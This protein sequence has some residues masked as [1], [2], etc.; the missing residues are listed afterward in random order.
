MLKPEKVRISPRTLLR[1]VVD[2][3]RIRSQERGLSL[4][5]EFDGPLPDS[6]LTD[7]T[8]FRQILL[9]LIGN[10]IKFTETGSVR[11][12]ARV[13]PADCRLEVR[14]I[15]T[16]IGIAPEDC[17]TLFEPFTQ[18][19]SS[20]TRRFGGTGLG[21]AISKRLVEMLGGT[22]A[23]ESV[24][25]KGSTFHFTITTGS[26]DG[27]SL[28]ETDDD[29]PLPPSSAGP[30]RVHGRRILVVDDRRDVR[31][32]VQ[33][34]LEEAGAEV[35]SASN[36]L[37]AVDEVA[38]AASRAE[39]FDAVL[40]DIQMPVMDGFEAARKLRE[41]GYRGAIIALTANA[42]RGD[43]ERCIDA[44]CNEY[45]SKPIDRLLL[46]QTV[47][48]YVSRNDGAA[49]TLPSMRPAAQRQPSPTRRAARH[50][51]LVEDNEDAAVAIATLLEAHGF[52]V[53]AATTGERGLTH[54][55]QRAPDV[56]ILDLGLP[57]IDGYETLARLKAMKGT[58]RTLC[59][60][61]SG[62]SAPEDHLRSRLAGFHHHL[63]KPVEIEN[64]LALMTEPR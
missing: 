24:L 26:L 47:A 35:R 53:D 28:T 57:D 41:E 45:L 10:A 42:M 4:E 58:E 14:V 49:A 40:L 38:R 1:E 30:S 27:V 20:G 55:E 15:D 23:V 44:G 50:V 56:A 60:A 31:Y 29:A 16:G 39:P 37:A 43:R 19:D 59:I 34:Y 17:A 36:G 13:H 8:R 62:R 18:V 2:N 3:L 9:N 7:P 46:I 12:R 51:L 11:V 64:L 6:I 33:T 25:G 54:A 52:S 61:L 21:L 5:L 32:L 63:V 22:I 48:N